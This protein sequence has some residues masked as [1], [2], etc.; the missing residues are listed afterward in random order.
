MLGCVELRLRNITSYVV[1]EVAL[2]FIEEAA[3]YLEEMLD[4][5]HMLSDQREKEKKKHRLPFQYFYVTFLIRR[6]TNTSNSGYNVSRI[7]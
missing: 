7:V 6:E 2:M 4:M 3:S 5:D 1:V